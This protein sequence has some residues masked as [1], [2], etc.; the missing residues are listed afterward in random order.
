[1]NEMTSSVE[2]IADYACAVAENPLWHAKLKRLLWTDIPTG[3]LYWFDPKLNSH[4]LLYKGRVVGGFTVQDDGSLLLFKD[5]GTITNLKDGVEITLVP[6]IPEERNQRFNDVIADP[7]GR[8][9]CGTFTEGLTGRLYR[10][11]RDGSLMKLLDGV[12]C[13]NGMAFSPDCQVFY[14]TDSFARTIYCFDY[15]QSDGSIRNQRPFYVLPEGRGFPDGCTVDSEGHL[16]FALWGGSSIVRLD[17]KAAVERSIRI[18]AQ[19]ATSLTF[20]G[21]HL[22]DL[23]VTS[24]GGEQRT[25]NDPLAGAVFHTRSDVA[26]RPEYFSR[27]AVPHQPS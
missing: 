26:G 13:S 18:P 24:E 20:A 14:F 8:V 12:G 19:K 15:D 4:G 17:P 10:L 23:Y 27:I 11:D 7:A 1:M 21:D 22:K 5:R 9:F 3:R 2:L 6:E 25:Q 16:W